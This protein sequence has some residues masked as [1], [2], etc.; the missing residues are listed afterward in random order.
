MFPSSTGF[1]P[2]A[3]S[4]ECRTAS[5]TALSVASPLT[6]A[7]PFSISS[8]ENWIPLEFHSFE[9]LVPCDSFDVLQGKQF[10]GLDLVDEVFIHRLIHAA[11]HK[12]GDGWRD[13]LFFDV[14]ATILLT[15]FRQHFKLGDGQV[16]LRV[17][18]QSSFSFSSSAMRASA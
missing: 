3:S 15:A 11:P 8:S 12:H 6:A 16:G 4:W 1:I 13:D 5:L 10:V 2:G 7:I 17:W 14:A 9:D 18:G